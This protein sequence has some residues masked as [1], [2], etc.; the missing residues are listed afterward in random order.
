LSAKIVKKL[1]VMSFLTISNSE[2]KLTDIDTK[3][4]KN[5][6]LRFFRKKLTKKDLI[7][8]FVPDKQ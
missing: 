6:F 4:L 8:I 5:T 2:D 1:E 3:Y 7:H